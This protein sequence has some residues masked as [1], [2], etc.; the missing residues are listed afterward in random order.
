VNTT[1][2]QQIN[3]SNLSLNIASKA[4]DGGYV[5][6]FGEDYY[7]IGNY[8]SLDPFF[9][10]LVS[11]SNHWLF[12]STTG[13]LTAGRINS[14]YALFPY[15]T[16]DKITENS[17]T[18][19]SKTILLVDTDDGRVIWEPFSVRY[20]GAYNVE[21][22]L[23]K[24]ISGTALVFE[25]INHDLGLTYR[26]SWR[27]SEAYGFVK[28]SYLLNQGDTARPIEILDGLQ[29]VLPAHV[30]TDV[31]NQLSNLLDAYK[32]N[33]LHKTTGLGLF[34]LSSRLT[35]L[36]EP[37]E[38]LRT[39]TVWQYGL[40][41]AKVLLSSSQIASFRR[42]LTIT[43]EEQIRGKRGAYFVNA[44]MSLEADEM[45][46]W[47]FVA[48][49]EQNSS[50]VAELVKLLS[51]KSDDLAT[52]VEDD[53]QLNQQNL[54]SIIGTSDGLQV[55][56]D[57]LST[58]HHYANVLFNVMRG[59]IF[60]DNYQIDVADLRNFIATHN[61]KLLETHADFFAGLPESLT[62]SKLYEQVNSID[63]TDLIRLAYSYLP[64]TFSRRHGDPSRPWNQFEINVKRDD[65]SQKLDYQGNWRDIFQNWEAL[66]YSYPQ[67]IDA[68][69]STFLN[70]TTVDGYN[71]YRIT[72]DGIDW[73]VPE[74][75]NGWANIG[76]WNDHQ[77]IYLQKLLE[78]SERFYPEKLQSLLQR[79]IFSYADVPYRIKTYD[80]LIVDAYDTIDF[81]WDR[82][83][84][85]NK[86]V[87]TTGADGKLVHDV[88]GRVVYATLAE[89]LL[90]LLLTKLTNLVPEGGIWLNTQR[91]EWNDANNALVGKGLSVVT[92]SYV[93][94][95]I[96]FY[97]T[98][99]KTSD[100]DTLTINQNLFTLWRMIN[101]TLQAHQTV[102]SGAISDQDRR[103]IVDALGTAGSDYRWQFYE[104]GVASSFEELS[105]SELVN[106]LE[107]AQQYIEHSLY[108]N[109]R[110]DNLYHAYNTLHLS[111]DSAEI[112]HLSVMLEGQVSILSSGLLSADESLE[113][114]EAMRKSDIYR[115]DQHSYMLYPNRDVA[116]FLE[117]NNIYA[118]DV[119]G[120]AL[121]SAMQEQGDSRLMTQ[122]VNGTYHF[123]G[124][125]RN[126]KDV[127]QTLDILSQEPLYVE[128][129]S[130]ESQQILDLFEKVFN[131]AAFT[132]RSS[133][134]FAFEGLG[135][136]YWHMV[137]KLL[138]AV[139]ETA[140]NAAESDVPDATLQQL[141]DA[142]YD[143]RAGIGF[144]KTPDV[145]GAFPTDPYSHTP[146]G[147]G[148]KQPGMTGM[149]KEEVLTRFV[150]LG[151]V[152][153]DGMIVFRPTLFREQ[154]FLSV[155]S[156]LKYID[157]NGEDRELDVPA[158]CL[159]FSLCQ[160][161]MI[162]GQ[163]DETRIEI[164]YTDQTS[165]TISGNRL[166]TNVSQSIFSRSG[167]VRQVTI[168]F[169]RA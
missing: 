99:L 145:Y 111:E 51:D 163:G 55:S 35:D 58:A 168:T 67:F 65:G 141:V 44:N 89:K 113:L 84:V 142:Y 17:E 157:I 66:S 79:R 64:L 87:E 125:I 161:P 147:Q 153:E 158:G 5:S 70:A 101:E 22:N 162:L 10:T 25:E 30:S 82:E 108:A 121:V 138:L 124:D 134:F 106:F 146:F 81:D 78:V 18:T 53:I 159:A 63:D 41:D 110:D 96:A 167:R 149:V 131:H 93:R 7:R 85:V 19:G 86:R 45:K 20:D 29:N 77:I 126:A 119:K 21:R 140:L 155:S 144:N 54:E 136:I 34:S 3:L 83:E 133:T 16:V 47:H 68:M 112:D 148:A 42:G 43:Q 60:A 100:I 135:S 132:G 31:Q 107:L 36:A 150:E 15:Y 50:Q 12:I 24:N 115:A 137:S 130:Q 169:N 38:S 114:L 109:K 56:K 104:T 116:G 37:S 95:Y 129:V 52:K 75:T 6:L 143:V 156:S 9:I 88:D 123:S 13:G 40:D 105:T 91:P 117:K 94:R 49:V 139:Q 62:L 92:L 28:T 2:K 165:E 33:E 154:E 97:K 127:N 102:L 118:D 27:T 26:Y 14:Q 164:E 103:K 1:D 160:V 72:R 57:K 39:N 61:T 98:L 80:N 8:D 59:G 128:L 73:E 71:P 46:Q 69:I 152:V 90:V 48:E 32:L 4:V 166:G 122:D 23:Y 74:P 76:Y 151:I 120:L 11:S